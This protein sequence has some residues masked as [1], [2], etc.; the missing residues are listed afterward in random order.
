MVHG[1]DVIKAGPGGTVRVRPVAQV[2][3]TRRCADVLLDLRREGR[4][5]AVVLDEFGGTAGIVTMEDLLEEL[6][7]EIFDE[8]DE[9]QR[10]G[11][12]QGRAVLVVDASQPLTALAEQFGV[13]LDAPARVATVGGY[14]AWALGRIPQS[15]ERHVAGGLEF[16][17]L[18]GTPSRVGKLVVRRAPEGAKL[19][20]RTGGWTT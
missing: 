3:A 8:T 20:E 18:E 14:V 7:G 16:D 17:V 6:V 1:F 15:G 13:V 4:H 11:A 5:L 19:P 2:P 12:A 9:P 10:Q